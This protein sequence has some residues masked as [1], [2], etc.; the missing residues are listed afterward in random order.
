MPPTSSLSFRSLRRSL[1][2]AGGKGRPPRKSRVSQNSNWATPRKSDRSWA[3]ELQTGSKKLV[4][5]TPPRL[6]ILPSALPISNRTTSRTVK[7]IGAW[8]PTSG[9]STRVIELYRPKASGTRY[10]HMSPTDNTRE[11]EE[12]AGPGCL[13][14]LE[15]RAHQPGKVD[16][17]GHRPLGRREAPLEDDR[18]GVV[19]AK[20]YLRDSQAAGDHLALLGT[21]TATPT[22]C[23]RTKKAK[24]K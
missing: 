24:G 3:S 11:L 6:S 14:Q 22:P 18:R 5:T 19:R 10:C 23:K 4:T 9:P 7:G 15:S 1:Q 16:A 8:R 17:E 12:V 2:S 20:G 13:W 21:R